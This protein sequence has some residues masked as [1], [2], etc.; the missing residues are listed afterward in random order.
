MGREVRA[1]PLPRAGLWPGC[2]AMT[3]C[4]AGFKGTPSARHAYG[5]DRLRELARATQREPE[6]PG[7]R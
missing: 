6:R 7:D 3:T 2:D 4:S 5:W 1:W